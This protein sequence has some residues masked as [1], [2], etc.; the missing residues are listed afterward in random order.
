[1]Q[2]SRSERGSRRLLGIAFAICLIGIAQLS[3]AADLVVTFSGVLPPADAVAELRGKYP[4]KD[5][6]QIPEFGLY[7]LH[8]DPIGDAQLRALIERLRTERTVRGID[9]APLSDSDL[10]VRPIDDNALTNP[11]LAQLQRIRSKVRAA[12]AVEARELPILEAFL[13]AS[14]ETRLRKFLARPSIDVVPDWPIV[15]TSV[16]FQRRNAHLSWSGITFNKPSQAGGLGTP[17]GTAFVSVFP[18]QHTKKPHIWGRITGNREVVLIR[19]LGDGKHAVIRLPYDGIHYDHGDA[20]REDPFARPPAPAPAPAPPPPP[21]CDPADPSC[22]QLSTWVSLCDPAP[23][24]APVISVGVLLQAPQDDYFSLDE[25]SEHLVDQLNRAFQCSK[26]KAAA[27][28][29]KAEAKAFSEPDTKDN[30]LNA[31]RDCAGLV[32]PGG[33]GCSLEDIYNWRNDTASD[34]VLILSRSLARSVFS[35]GYSKE[36]AFAVID[37]GLG[38]LQKWLPEPG[39]VYDYDLTALHELGHVFGGAHDLESCQTDTCFDESI[40]P[41][42]KGHAY[43][44][45]GTPASDRFCTAVAKSPCHREPYFSTPKVPLNGVNI[46]SATENVAKIITKRAKEIS[47][48]R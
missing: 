6:T 10:F 4:I 15:A 42:D 47:E 45:P 1:M 23:A 21:V 13:D 5:A 38:G 28:L 17:T 2:S 34:V 12:Y 29:T 39:Y 26:A 40:F 20:P 7:K 33:S 3:V 27:V 14:L 48:F 46:G 31:F 25:Y 36:L 30:Y 35:V 11:Q 32:P 8:I 41:S 19:P 9:I 24:D 16:Y 37:V 22:P 18:E 43:V 44:R